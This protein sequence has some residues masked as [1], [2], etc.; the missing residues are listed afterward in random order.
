MSESSREE[1]LPVV[2]RI[3]AVLA[4]LGILVGVVIGFRR[5][6]GAS[7][8]FEIKGYTDAVLIPIA[9][10]GAACLAA[11]VHFAQAG[12]YSKAMLGVFLLGLV[13]AASTFL[14][15]VAIVLLV[16]AV[17]LSVLANL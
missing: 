7:D 10:G 5:L 11:I 6:D 3:G 9:L 1:P 4:L 12:R 16:I 8:L 13:A 15:G 17:V 2:L 14:V